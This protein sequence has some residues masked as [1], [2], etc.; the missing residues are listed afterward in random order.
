MNFHWLKY[1]LWITF[2]SP[3]HLIHYFINNGMSRLIYIFG[4]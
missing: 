2:Y 3:I 1:K 4:S